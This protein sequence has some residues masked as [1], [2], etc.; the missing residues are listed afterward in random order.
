M[1]DLNELF[2]GK[3]Y[4]KTVR[5]NLQEEYKHMAL[6]LPGTAVAI[7]NFEKKQILLQRRTDDGYI[8]MI[9]G[10]I[11]IVETFEQCAVREVFEETGLIIQE[12]HLRLFKI[13]KGPRLVTVHPNDDMVIHINWATF[14]DFKD[15]IGNLIVSNAK[16]KEL[17]WVSYSEVLDLDLFR[18][19]RPMLEEIIAEL[20]KK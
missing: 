17:L 5:T 15:C 2:K 8:G 1:F 19:N 14:V 6:M 7:I 10:G 20:Q 16:T 12:G 9:G 11:G 18:A 4:A 3:D 13:F